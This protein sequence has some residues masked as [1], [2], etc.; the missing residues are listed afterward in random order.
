MMHH[1]NQ[2]ILGLKYKSDPID[3][4]VISDKNQIILGLK[5]MFINLKSKS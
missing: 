3:I 5:N 1:K 2:I 4:F